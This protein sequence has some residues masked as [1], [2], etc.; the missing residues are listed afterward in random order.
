MN[1]SKTITRALI[2]AA[3]VA[4]AVA[5]PAAAQ[6]DPDARRV[7]RVQHRRTI[8]RTGSPRADLSSSPPA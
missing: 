5:L 8:G 7:M 3:T 6:A 2:A 4:A 1:T